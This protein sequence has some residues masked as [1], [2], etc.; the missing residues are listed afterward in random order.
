MALSP[1]ALPWRLLP[2]TVADQQLHL[3]YGQ[4]LLDG[5][6][7]PQPP[8]LYWSQADRPGL[9][10]GL[11]QKVAQLNR[12]ALQ[13]LALPLYQRQAGGT[14]VLVGP[15]LLA[16]DVFLPPGHPFILPDVVE[17]YRWLGETWVAA[18]ARLGIT[19][20]LVLPTEA[21]AQ[22]ALLKEPATAQREALLRRACY[23]SLSPY[24]VVAFDQRK[25]VGLTMIRRR[26]GSLLQ[27]GLLLRWEVE[28]LAL[29][30][31]LTDTE[32]AVLRSELPQRAVGLETLAGRSFAVAEVITAFEEALLARPFPS[33]HAQEKRSTSP[34]E[35]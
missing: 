32:Q 29:V 19:T 8:T 20:R 15:H 34:A 30:L 4:Q 13:R 3:N 18:L 23:G 12:E 1:A 26:T 31:G 14:A 27:C 25:V 9:V 24:E 33:R 7:P 10:L 6:Q 35:T 5:S 21:R 2:L 28:P 11:S 16:L 22:Q 17:S